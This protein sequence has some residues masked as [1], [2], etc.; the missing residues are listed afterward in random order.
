MPVPWRLLASIAVI[1]LVTALGTGCATVPP[2]SRAEIQAKALGNLD[3]AGAWEAGNPQEGAVQDNW[4]ATF[5]DEKLT[6]LVKEAL[7]NNLDLQIAASRVEQ[8]AGY[9]DV[10]QAALYPSLNLF[11]SRR[12]KIRGGGSELSSPVQALELGISWE[13]DVWGRVRY[14]RNAA[15]E[16][17]ASAKADFEFARQSLA[18]LVTDVW[19]V[20][21]QTWL[22][23][24]LGEQIIQAAEELV[25]IAEKR[26]EVGIGNEQDVASARANLGNYQD[27]MRQV[28]FAHER[29]LRA[30]EVLLGRY[31]SADIEARKDLPPLPGPVPAGMKVDILE[32]RPDVTAAERRVAAAFNRVGESKAARLPRI[33]LN[34]NIGLLDV[35]S[36]N[37][38]M[39]LPRIAQNPASAILSTRRIEVEKSVDNPTGS[40]DA[41]LYFPVYEGGALKAQVEIR[42]AEQREA[43][44]DYARTVLAALDDVENALGLAKA[45]SEREVV[46]HQV[47]ADSQI[48]L[49][50]AM[51]NFNIGRQ[52]PRIVQLYQMDLHEARITLLLVQTEQLRQRVKLHLAL[53]GS[54]EVPTEPAPTD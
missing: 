38:K 1:V 32:R 40:M 27:A 42:N 46:L 4:I 43:I 22:Q 52:D 44:A 18:A 10:A 7:E 48:A 9:V 36:I 31:P 5:S 37:F 51:A 21:T 26:Y 33:S 14:G 3:L 17:Y 50:H 23:Q 47:V 19:F 11:G 53:G 12:A 20:A 28:A 35:D 54:F 25:R 49:D 34:T 41:G 8:A 15:Q 24:Q 30:L 39:R 2:P 16:A 29:A 13:P 45:L 6:V